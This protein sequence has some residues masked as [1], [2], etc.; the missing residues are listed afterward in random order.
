MY[1]QVCY[2]ADSS[3]TMDRELSALKNISDNY[4]KYIVTTD[5]L[6]TGS[7]DGIQCVHI[8]DFL[9][10]DLFQQSQCIVTCIAKNAM[11]EIGYKTRKCVIINFLDADDA[12]DA[13]FS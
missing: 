6:I 1:V 2:R 5:D 11:N 9:M 4:P 7:Y 10:M 3:T 13:D 12:D 8:C